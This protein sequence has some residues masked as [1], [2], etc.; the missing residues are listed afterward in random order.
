MTIKHVTLACVNY[1]YETGVEE[2][3]YSTTI[4]VF[5]KPHTFI[6][7]KTIIHMKLT[8]MTMSIKT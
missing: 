6:V 7:H 5:I 8:S 3:N 4:L 2:D 1:I